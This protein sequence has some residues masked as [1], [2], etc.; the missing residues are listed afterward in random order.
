MWGLGSTQTLQFSHLL[1]QMAGGRTS[2]PEDTWV[3]RQAEEGFI[4]GVPLLVGGKP[5]L[6][7]ASVVCLQVH[8]P[9]SFEFSQSLL[10]RPGSIP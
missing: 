5:W 1:N 10:Q 6:P 4:A 9:W 8:T 3:T 2:S 7:K